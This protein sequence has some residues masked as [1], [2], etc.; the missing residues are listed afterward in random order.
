MKIFWRPL[1]HVG[2]SLRLADVT[3]PSNAFLQPDIFVTRW[4]SEARRI[5]RVLSNKYYGCLR[6]R[7]LSFP[8]PAKHDGGFATTLPTCKRRCVEKLLECYTPGECTWTWRIEFSI[9]SKTGLGEGK[10]H[11]I[12][13]RAALVFLPY[14]KHRSGKCLVLGNHS[15][16]LAQPPWFIHHLLIAYRY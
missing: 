5:Q 7:A 9:S 13:F 12:A 10:R 15:C 1:N 4:S 6:K 8:K 2:T 16:V 11:N 14:W 3:P